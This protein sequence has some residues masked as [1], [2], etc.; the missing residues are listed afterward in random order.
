MPK[1][2]SWTVRLLVSV[3]VLAVLLALVPLQQLAGA[4][5]GVSPA[6]W[7]GAVL[8]FLAAHA[9][10]AFKWQLL[11]CHGGRVPAGTWLRAH[12]AGLAANLCLP[13]IA[14]GDVVRAAW[15]RRS[16]GSLEQVA[17]AGLADRAIDCVV[18]LL[19][20]AAGAATAGGV[21]PS[22][23]GALAMVAAALGALALGA[24]VAVAA[25][26]RRARD[27]RLRRLADAADLI[28]KRPALPLACFGLSLVI[29]TIFVTINVRLG[30][31][32][33][34][35][36]G[37]S[38]WLFAWPLAKL[39]ALAPVSLSGLG[40]REAALVTFLKP[41]GAAPAAVTAAGLVWQSVLAA[42]GVAGWLAGS[43]S[44]RPT[45]AD[46]ERTVQP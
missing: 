36:A 38:A 14:G 29:Q 20:A 39:V 25:V 30:A 34:V 12:F 2:L 27:G 46:P 3:G 6:L 15:V 41:F 43:V 32:T 45:L 19:L 11:L 5:A 42:G 17:V 40:V 26:R 16:T 23:R 8:T 21:L 10:A 33:G 7:G 4:I 37:L 13:G 44:A 18:L 31:E 9:I 22:S 1:K 24:I 35:H 28:A